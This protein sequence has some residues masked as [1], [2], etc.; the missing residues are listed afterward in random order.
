MRRGPNVGRLS[1]AAGYRHFDG[2][3]ELKNDKSRNTTGW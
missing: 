3:P 1:E 2:V